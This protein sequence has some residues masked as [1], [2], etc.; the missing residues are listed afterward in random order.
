MGNFYKEKLKTDL[1]DLV[2]SILAIL[3]VIGL[4]FSLFYYVWHD[5]KENDLDIERQKLSQMTELGVTDE[6]NVLVAKSINDNTSISG[7]FF[8]FSGSITSEVQENLRIG[9]NAKN[10]K[11]YILRIPIRRIEFLVIEDTIPSARMTFVNWGLKSD[12]QGN[13]DKYMDTIEIKITP[14]QYKQLINS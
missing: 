4:V 9:Y 5:I 12:L 7:S 14:D 8:L 11:S 3:L 10:G 6:C 2:G 1:V 13:I